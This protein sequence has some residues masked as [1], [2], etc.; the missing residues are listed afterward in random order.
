MEIE[1]NTK[2]IHSHEILFDKRIPLKKYCKMIIIYAYKKLKNIM[3]LAE[4]LKIPIK[5]YKEP[6]NFSYYGLNNLI[7][8]IEK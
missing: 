3:I 2:F 1:D 7:D 5:I 4:E 8:L 6:S